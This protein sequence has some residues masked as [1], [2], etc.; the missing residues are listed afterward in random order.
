MGMMTQGCGGYGESERE[1]E[2]RRRETD[3]KGQWMVS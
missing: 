1:G 2:S 3:R